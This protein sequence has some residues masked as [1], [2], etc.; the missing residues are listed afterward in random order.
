MA[1]PVASQELNRLEEKQ[2]C[3]CGCLSSTAQLELSWTAPTQLTE[4]REQAA[5]AG[6]DCGC[7]SSAE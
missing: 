2:D 5:S 3:G 7:L 4:V 1:E 6:C